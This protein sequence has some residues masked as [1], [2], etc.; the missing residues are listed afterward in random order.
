MSQTEELRRRVEDN[1][2]RRELQGMIQDDPTLLSDQMVER[3]WEVRQNNPWINQSPEPWKAALTFYRGSTVKRGSQV[4]P[5]PKGDA[6]KPPATPVSPVSRV[7][8]SVDLSDTNALKELSTEDLEQ[9]AKQNI[10]GY[11]GI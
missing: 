3:L 5:N 9:L 2:R 10:K 6:A 4:V 8:K 1:E 11:R 7:T